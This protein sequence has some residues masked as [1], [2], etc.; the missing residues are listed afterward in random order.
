MSYQH[1]RIFFDRMMREYRQIR[2]C[3]VSFDH[4]SLLHGYLHDA[5][6]T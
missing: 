4:T 3:Y 5:V 6:H 2:F 1:S